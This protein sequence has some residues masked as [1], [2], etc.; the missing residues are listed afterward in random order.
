[1][2]GDSSGR[3]EIAV[4]PPRV[5]VTEARWQCEQLRLSGVITLPAGEAAALEWHNNR[6][7]RLFGVERRDGDRFEAVFEP[8]ARPGPEGPRPVSSGT[9]DLYRHDRRTG[10]P[11]RAFVARGCQVGVETAHRTE[12]VD[13]HLWVDRH[14][15]VSMVVHELPVA[16]R[17]PHAQEEL[18]RGPYRRARAGRLR[19][20]VLF[21]SWQGKQFSDNPR[22]LAEEA[23]RRGDTRDLMVAVRDSS[24]VVPPGLRPVLRWS[25]EYYE[26]LATARTVI[27]ND[28]LTTHYVKREDQRYVQTW[29]GTPLKRIGFDIE[30]IHFRNQRY[31]QELELE[32]RKWDLLL[33]PNAHTTKILRSAF[34]YDGE[35][36][37]T[38]YPRNDLLLRPEAA[39]VRE[40][41]REWLG[42]P[43]G[44]TAVLWA[45]TWRDNQFGE[46][47]GYS[48]PM[49]LDLVRLS[50]QLGDGHVILFRGH[51]L[52][53]DTMRQLTGGDGFFLNVSDHP[54]IRDL[55]CASDVLVTD[56]S[57]TMFDYALTG[58]PILHLVWDLAAYRDGLRGLYLDL[59]EIAPGP[60]LANGDQLA[61]ALLDL[62]AV[63]GQYAARYRAF[64][65]RF[66][67]LEDGR[68]SAR[69]WDRIDAT[70]VAAGPADRLTG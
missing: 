63:A 19:D 12:P 38:G 32:T 53:S 2:R 42:V 33:S 24:V 6:G 58:R 18:R 5:A 22:A 21:E 45:P 61:E 55:Y 64:R 30:T 20:A 41:T 26:A 8:L 68:S 14:S 50:R 7:E 66:C 31:L 29:H 13:V 34:R 60:L 35:I 23:L 62:S 9:W 47:R 44:R 65:E 28:S 48:F 56:Y 1:V 27:A 16:E 69:A 67:A 43:P 3:A 70:P 40:R 36:A 59:A 4:T 54:D 51:H 39:A 49:V 15:L 57:S 10:Q 46:G 25:R 17:G 37:E 52:I 11:T